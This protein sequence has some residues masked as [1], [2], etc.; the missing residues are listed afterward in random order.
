MFDNRSEFKRYF[1]PLLND[2]DIKP[3]LTAI[4]NPQDN[5]PVEWVHQVVLNMLVA[6]DLDKKVFNHI[7]P[8][9]E[10]LAYI[11]WVIRASYHCTIMATPGQDVFDRESLF[12]LAS[13]I[14]WK[15]VTTAKQIQVDIDNFQENARRFTHDYAIGNQ[16]YVEMTGI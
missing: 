11:A 8:W 2:F 4:K 7:D 14:N 1:T 16:V 5:D 12:D 9:G 10:T 6:K 15:V 3:V 13:V